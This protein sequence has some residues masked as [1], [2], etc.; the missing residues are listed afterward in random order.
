M[1]SVAAVV[2]GTG[3]LEPFWSLVLR[4]LLVLWAL[5]RIMGGEDSV[6]KKK[7]WEMWLIKVDLLVTGLLRAFNMITYVGSLK[8]SFLDFPS[9]FDHEAFWGLA[10][11][12]LQSGVCWRKLRMC[13]QPG[14]GASA[15]EC[16]MIVCELHWVCQVRQV[17]SICRHA[18]SSQPSD[19]QEYGW[20]NQELCMLFTQKASL[21]RCG[22]SGRAGLSDCCA[23]TRSS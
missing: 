15:K 12:V 16:N 20:K 17:L 5:R 14:D 4:K 21:I 7:N 19:L 8:R 6:A 3:N 1:G 9:N 18:H 11:N 23:F 2:G 10:L 22:L 13:G